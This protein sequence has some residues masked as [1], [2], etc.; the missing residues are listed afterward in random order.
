MLNENSNSKITY[1][2][3]GSDQNYFDTRYQTF[4][5]NTRTFEDTYEPSIV[6][7]KISGLFSRK[8]PT[9]T[10]NLNGPKWETEETITLD[11]KGNQR[12]II[13]KNIDPFVS[14]S[15]DLYRQGSEILS[16]S[17]WDKGFIKIL[18][19]EPGHLLDNRFYGAS[20]FSLDEELYKTFDVTED[21]NLNDRYVTP[22][23][24]NN[25]YVYDKKGEKR[26]FQQ[27]NPDSFKEI[28][29]LTPDV[30]VSDIEL[31]PM[32][33]KDVG[34]ATFGTNGTIEPL[35]IRETI[36]NYLSEYPYQFRSIKS[37]FESGNTNIYGYSDQV[38]SVD[39]W[40][41]ERKNK[42]FYDDNVDAITFI[43]SDGSKFYR[44][45]GT[46]F[47]L[48]SLGY[49]SFSSNNYIKPFDDNKPIFKLD[50]SSYIKPGYRTG[51]C[52][53]MY[54]NNIGTE[55]IAYGDM[56]FL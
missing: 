8:S 52:G 55:S 5:T 12:K 1:L 30:V 48:E 2:N 22:T 34:E 4:R 32:V 37:N 3:I 10:T 42:D 18:S 35:T 27:K 14:S 31:Y 15:F 47:T 50:D 38:L 13:N 33:I 20:K 51:A 29:V 9:K 28:H 17:Q 6:E 45:D 24:E 16:F 53:F 23:Y 7:N 36:T 46:E 19:G 43:K 11:S 41:P 44:E 39:L 21:N 26:Y 40:E 54:N 49:T 25:K 56:I